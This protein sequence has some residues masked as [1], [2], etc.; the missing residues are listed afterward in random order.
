MPYLI[1]NAENRGHK[2]Y[3]F[4]RKIS[5]GRH[6]G[7]HIMLH[8]S[9]GETIS[10]QHA[11]IKRE[12]KAFVLVDSSLN[13]TRM[14]GELIK[15]RELK[16][17]DRFHIAEYCLTF[18]DDSVVRVES[19]GHLV[20]NAQLCGKTH[21]DR[22]EKVICCEDVNTGLADSEIETK[23]K[24]LGIVAEDDQMLAIYKDIAAVSRINV[25]ILILGEPGTGKEKV[26]QAVHEFTNAEGE[27]VALNCSAI[28]EN[29]FENEL[30]GSVKGAFS[31]AT[32]KCGK[33]E[34]ADRG[35]LFL[36]EIGDMGLGCQPKLLRF[37]E[38]RT[39][40]RLGETRE[41]KLNL[42]VVAATNQD[43]KQMIAAKKFRPDL[44][45]RLACVK[46]VIPPLRK[47]KKDILPLADFFLKKYAGEYDLKPLNISQRAA[48]MMTAYNWPGNVRE[49]ANIMLNVCVRVQGRNIMPSHLSA[50]SEEIGRFDAVLDADVESLEVM[51]KHHIYRA[52]KHAGNNKT[53]ACSI[54]GI[55]KDTLYR[56]LKK[57][58][59]AG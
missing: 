37:L 22:T 4:L 51:E 24:D 56:K 11:S 2:I 12:N 44:F 29:L 32:T 7:C 40:S 39:L 28:P 33:I 46:L 3:H 43:L 19:E 58:E 5:I 50:A 15:T 34:M 13:G 35:T 9:D 47:R 6:P 53:K 49:L 16:H 52:L 1:V 38:T 20:Q 30:F 25:P 31:D 42:R 27:F 8:T 54:L 59:T 55:S 10:R 18:F 21:F 23:L 48:K 36:D 17:G 57:Y 26:A 14:D 45:Q 41:R